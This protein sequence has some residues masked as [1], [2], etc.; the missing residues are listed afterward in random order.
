MYK[1][2]Y[3]Y[4]NTMKDL[5]LELK[6]IGLTGHEPSVFVSL[7]KNG[8]CGAS[9]IASKCSLSRSSVYTTLQSLTGKG[10]VS[11]S[12]KN[13]VKQF[14]AND[15]ESMKLM[16][17]KHEQELED[18]FVALKNIENTFNELLNNKIGYVQS[19]VTFFEGQEG[20]KKV[21]LSMMRNAK[22]RD[23]LYLLRDEFV[24]NDDWKFIFESEWNSRVAR[25][26]KEKDINTQLLINDSSLERKAK[27][28]YDK[29][30]SLEYLFLAK[31]NSVKNYAQYILGD[32]VA[33]MSMEKSNLIGIQITNSGLAENHRKI[34]KNIWNNP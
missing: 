34:F 8:P 26:K 14:I 15:F 33:I 25:I 27:V 29:K 23:T 21:Y 11:L 32:M 16:V 1:V 4:D 18:K 28:I 12:H 19:D 6:R 10:L 9:L 17:R 30:R 5:N 22:K 3:K 31:D 7:L 20:L 24:W 13:E 2:S